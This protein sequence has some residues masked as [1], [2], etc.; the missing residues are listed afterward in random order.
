MLTMRYLLIWTLFLGASTAIP[1]A[2]N[3][4][5]SRQIAN[6]PDLEPPNRRCSFGPVAGP[7]LEPP[8]R[9]CRLRP[10]SI[11]NGPDLE[12]PIARPRPVTWTP[13]VVNP[14]P[15]TVNPGVNVGTSL[16]FG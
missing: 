15:I 7:D 6:G 16:N 11:A 5:Q 4:I 8:N 10:G 13:K 12:P 1:L 3:Q 2:G 14:R 9:L